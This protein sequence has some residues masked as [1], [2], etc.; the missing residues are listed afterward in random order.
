MGHLVI[1]MIATYQHKPV[2]PLTIDSILAASNDTTITTTA[3]AFL[4]TKPHAQIRTL[5]R[6]ALGRRRQMEVK[7]RFCPIRS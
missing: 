5:S 6:C 1:M 7:A 4:A 3:A 2:I